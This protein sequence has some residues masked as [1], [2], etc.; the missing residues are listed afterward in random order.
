MCTDG[1]KY[2]KGFE[3]LF[4]IM[5]GEGGSEEPG[6]VV[7]DC[8]KI[9][10]NILQNSETCQRLFFGMGGADWILRIT[11]YFDPSLLE[12]VSAKGRLA[13][14]GED[15]TD[16][17]NN[18]Q[19]S[20]ADSAW[21][22]DVHRVSCAILG[23]S[24]LFNSLATAGGDGG[25]IPSKKHQDLVAS[26]S[27]IVPSIVHW[28]ARNG[29]SDMVSAS[30]SLLS[31]LTEGN[32]DVV[33]QISSAVIAI[34]PA[35]SGKMIPNGE[36]IPTL[37][38]GWRPLP[39]EETRCITV[40]ALLAERYIFS[41]ERA[42]SAT[43]PS[44]NVNKLQLLYQ[45]NESS[46]L[47]FATTCLHVFEKLLAV[48]NSASD[49]MIQFVLAPPPPPA[50]DSSYGE[51]AELEMAKPLATLLFGIL[52]NGC[53]K[54]VNAANNPYGT[55][56][57][58]G[59][60]ASGASGAAAAEIDMAERCAN[61]LAVIFVHGT[62]LSRELAT[63]ITPAHA[64]NV[65]LGGIVNSAAS[66]FAASGAD[67]NALLPQ[68]L[69]AAGR[70]ARGASGPGGASATNLLI[71]VLRLLSVVST[72][73]ERAANL[74]L[75]DPA[76]LFVVDLAS[77][78]SESAGVPV[79]VQ[80]MSC[81]FLGC[82]FLSL[83]EPPPQQ[84]DRGVISPVPQD[85][86]VVNKRTF[87][88]MIDSRI[89][90]NRFT[91]M[92]KK[93]LRA[94]GNSGGAVSLAT[95][96]VSPGFK[97]FYESQV[98]GIRSGIFQFY[99]GGG[100]RHQIS[101]NGEGADPSQQQALID[102][103]HSRIAELEA[104]LASTNINISRSGQFTTEESKNSN[105]GSDTSDAAQ[106]AVITERESKLEA[107][108]SESSAE[109]NRLRSVV[110]QAEAKLQA[111][112][113]AE[114]SSSTAGDHLAVREGREHAL[115]EENLLLRDQL[116]SLETNH[117]QVNDTLLMRE[118]EI[119]KVKESILKD[120]EE[121][122]ALQEALD[123]RDRKIHLL[124]SGALAANS[125]EQSQHDAAALAQKI[126]DLETRNAELKQN[127][128]SLEGDLATAAS[129]A[130]LLTADRD[131]YFDTVSVAICTAATRMG[132]DIEDEETVR[133]KMKDSASTAVERCQLIES[134]LDNL[135]DKVSVVSNQCSDIAEGVGA[136]DLAG[137]EGSIDRCLDC[138][139]RLLAQNATIRDD[140]E[141]I[142]SDLALRELSVESAET[143][144]E[145][146]RVELDQAKAE[147]RRLE[148]LVSAPTV[149]TTSLDSDLELIDQLRVDI[150][151]LKNI[152]ESM[153]V[154]NGE[155][156]AQH[157]AAL[158]SSL[159]EL[160]TARAQV[161]A[162][163]TQLRSNA[164][165]SA[166]R[167]ETLSA[168]A[169]MLSGELDAAHQTLATAEG[170]KQELHLNCEKLRGE[171][172]AAATDLGRLNEEVQSAKDVISINA[173]QLKSDEHRIHELNGEVDRLI[174]ENE[175]LA[176]KG[177][178][179]A[180]ELNDLKQQLSDANSQVLLLQD[181]LAQRK[182]EVSALQ[183]EKTVIQERLNAALN[184]SDGFQAHGHELDRLTVEADQLARKLSERDDE[185]SKVMSMLKRR[186]GELA[187]VHTTLEGFEADLEAARTEN[188]DMA[189]SVQKLNKRVAEL[190][191][192]NSSL[193]SALQ[194]EKSQ[195]ASALS[196][197]EAKQNGSKPHLFAAEDRLSSASERLRQL[198]NWVASTYELNL[199]S[200]SGGHSS[201]S[202]S[203]SSS[204]GD[205][206]PLAA[207]T[208]R[209][210]QAIIMLAEKLQS[211]ISVQKTT[212]RRMEN[213]RDILQ[214]AKDSVVIS[215]PIK[216]NSSSLSSALVSP[217]A[218]GN[219]CTP[220]GLNTV[221]KARYRGARSI[222]MSA[223]PEAKQTAKLNSEMWKLVRPLYLFICSFILKSSCYHFFI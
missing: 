110:A 118:A 159:E 97:T 92:M 148:E 18:G 204:N 167:L 46:K 162:L 8:L 219:S 31:A 136:T 12:K 140:Q 102:I 60:G 103:Q 79:A 81:L 77:E 101:A 53:S 222:L 42:W 188:D 213:E 208:A 169:V 182:E 85:D 54:A 107:A 75:E 210:K 215:T 84:S 121:K 40:P 194:L 180:V 94:G 203:S 67:R 52:M 189:D 21:F 39:L 138:C 209:M 35:Q 175:V 164:D 183:S 177:H 70:A 27:F 112:V 41:V 37:L 95:L 199:G 195:A 172:S 131:R 1:Y 134:V 198:L 115:Q 14:L 99:A 154:S 100:G 126:L 207:C 216:S 179:T 90:L 76:N 61:V 132:V 6:V 105:S 176:S 166:S 113:S 69:F 106:T 130:A 125:L 22:E 24:C 104:I 123:Q 17:G 87:L 206:D 197:L 30:L 187:G 156:A 64:S 19:H 200:S 161:S 133:A 56:G 181:S 223:S 143:A 157:A 82:C 44:F 2:T 108:L 62:Q 65:S 139:R 59:N 11:D 211:E 185:L 32:A 7:M 9:C 190:Q 155:A 192:E 23:I 218:L 149:S 158:A 160:E 212:I 122:R 191:R 184:R 128:W 117:K 86:T 91:E 5:R 49:M 168:Q 173:Q 196:Q 78:A 119:L 80:V 58:V 124:E 34:S 3:I 142:E 43:S 129:S 74:M 137:S 165:D 109:N 193:Q 214:A 26:A 147:N 55:S 28:I 45:L 174:S 48:D 151:N 29:P 20:A 163:Q 66:S 4:N 201:S 127:V 73:C 93:P 120:M 50:E 68:L 16:G 144:L 96:F 98:D 150:T 220:S 111:F 153:Q 171:L 221:E 116:M 89:G 63:A 71:A 202:S 57:M 178:S 83:P 13:A 170:D 72:G 33:A 141:R 51:D 152:V 114:D 186:E 88:S 146:T 15:G 38:F 217:H 205:D 36:P 145:E 10:N 47:S 25:S 135:V